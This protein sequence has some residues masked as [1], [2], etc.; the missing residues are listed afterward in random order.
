MS[1]IAAIWLFDGLMIVLILHTVLSFISGFFGTRKGGTSSEKWTYPDV[2]NV[3]KAAYW[4]GQY[5]ALNSGSFAFGDSDGFRDSRTLKHLQGGKM[6]DPYPKQLEKIQ[7]ALDAFD[8]DKD[9]K[10]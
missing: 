6:P 8:I 2:E 3:A 9:M 5:D 1:V 7:E 4:E 10:D